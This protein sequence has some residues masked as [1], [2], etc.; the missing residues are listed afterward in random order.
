[1]TKKD[2]I[3]YILDTPQNV[4]PAILN[5]MLDEVSGGGASEGEYSWDN[6]YR[7]V[8]NNGTIQGTDIDFIVNHLPHSVVISDPQ[9]SSANLF[10][11]RYKDDDR[12]TFVKYNGAN[13]AS[14]SENYLDITLKNEVTLSVRFSALDFKYD[15][16]KDCYV[17]GDN[18]TK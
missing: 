10:I 9:A 15:A 3:D 18:A 8:I 12:Y 2:L 17:F 14:E 11:F 7:V 1:M 5:Q 4:N 6:A 13:T 16:E